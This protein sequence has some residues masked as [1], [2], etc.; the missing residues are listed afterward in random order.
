MQDWAIQ[1]IEHAESD[2]QAAVLINLSTLVRRLCVERSVNEF[3]FPRVLFGAD[4][5]TGKVN[6]YV[7]FLKK[8]LEVR[9][10]IT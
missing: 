9:K 3:I 1:N 7:Q 5:C 8:Q 2:V 6:D 10:H 4:T